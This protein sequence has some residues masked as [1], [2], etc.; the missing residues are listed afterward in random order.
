VLKK[1]S[2]LKLAGFLGLS[3]IAFA[4][5]ACNLFSTKGSASNNSSTTPTNISLNSIS[6]GSYHSCILT[7][8]GGVQ[9]WGFNLFG[10]LGNGNTANSSTAVA[11]TGLS[12]GVS[13]IAV[14]GYSSCAIVN[15]AVQ[16]WGYNGFGQLGNN[17]TTNSSIPVAAVNQLTSGVT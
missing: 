13:Q 6:S 15:G 3:L 7:Q 14:G 5:S 12:S 10:Q 9:C 1:N 4:L 17:T 16:C 8:G 2:T 11:V